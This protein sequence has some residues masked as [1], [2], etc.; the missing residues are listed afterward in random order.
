MLKAV[1]K[2]MFQRGAAKAGLLVILMIAGASSLVLSPRLGSASPNFVP[3]PT[4]VPPITVGIDADPGATPANTATTLG[5]IEYCRTVSNGAT[6]TV[7]F[8]VKNIPAPGIDA[9]QGDLHYPST[10]LEVTGM[11]NFLM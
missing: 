9:F 1:P 3:S 6:F 2:T 11:N 8:Y 4:P 7:D 5:T 10:K